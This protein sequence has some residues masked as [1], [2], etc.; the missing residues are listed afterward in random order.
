MHAM[1]ETCRVFRCM[2]LGVYVVAVYTHTHTHTC[3]SLFLC[4][5]SVQPYCLHVCLRLSRCAAPA[6]CALHTSCVLCPVCTHVCQAGEGCDRSFL[7]PWA[8]SGSNSPTP[9][10]SSCSSPTHRLE[11]PR[12]LP[13]MNIPSPSHQSRGPFAAQIPQQPSQSLP[14]KAP[15]FPVHPP[16]GYV[17]VSLTHL[18]MLTWRT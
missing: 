6:V 15:S 9:V 3:V 8:C 13:C 14:D 12:G 10:T 5:V 11:I 17:S 18:V 7:Q 1:C 16:P 4:S 2:D